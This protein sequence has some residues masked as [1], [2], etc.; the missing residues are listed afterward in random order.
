MDPTW[1]SLA[2]LLRGSVGS[3]D[4]V[5][6]V[7]YLHREFIGRLVRSRVWWTGELEDAVQDVLL[8][9][10][11]KILPDGLP[12]GDGRG[13]AQCW[14][15]AVVRN[16]ST[17]WLRHREPRQEQSLGER[18]E[19]LDAYLVSVGSADARL[20]AQERLEELVNRLEMDPAIP[21]T[22][23]LAFLALTIPARL[24]SEQVG[25]A[26][27]YEAGTGA[28]WGNAGLARSAEE[29]WEHLQEWRREHY[30]DPRCRRAREHLAWVLRCDWPPPP[31]RW[32]ETNQAEAATARDTVG[33]W[34][35]RAAIRL[36]K[37]RGAL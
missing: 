5:W 22:H 37:Q 10:H 19:D 13:S 16:M 20:D 35:R 24:R 17:D 18:V 6:Q 14:F 36:C 2:P 12:V 23:A 25:R 8:K 28:H 34:S 30:R 7:L 3:S 9:L 4:A 15:A 32:V 11:E 33:R 1:Q 26:E 21:P 27:H 31:S 29:T